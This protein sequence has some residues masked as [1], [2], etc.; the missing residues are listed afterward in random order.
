MSV[1]SDLGARNL[2]RKARQQEA[3]PPEALWEK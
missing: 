3:A 1:S 2:G